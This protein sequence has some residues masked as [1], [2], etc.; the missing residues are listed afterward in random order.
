M[1]LKQWK[2]RGRREGGR[3][4]GKRVLRELF[5]NGKLRVL[6]GTAYPRT[7]TRAGS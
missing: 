4:K 2:G 7:T 1:L 5:Y 6:Q 3:G